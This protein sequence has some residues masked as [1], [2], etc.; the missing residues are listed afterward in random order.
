M[1]YIACTVVYLYIDDDRR[2]TP[3]FIS[4]GKRREGIE[5]GKDVALT[6][7]QCSTK[8]GIEVILCCDT[9]SEK[10]FG[11]AVTGFAEESLGNSGFDLARMRNCVVFIEA[12]DPA[13]I[14]NPGYVV[15][16]NLR[17]D[18]VLP[19][20]LTTIPYSLKGWRAQFDTELTVGVDQALRYRCAVDVV[21][22][23]L[24]DPYCRWAVQSNPQPRAHGNSR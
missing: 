16:D 24:Y 18:H 23:V 12:N 1:N 14:L 17:L 11:L 4:E 10:L 2:P 21:L 9:P 19:L 5:C 8:R 22:A 13:E 3:R 15:I 7:D 20:R 6:G